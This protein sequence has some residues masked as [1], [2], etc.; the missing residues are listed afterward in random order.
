MSIDR[1]QDR[2]SLGSFTFVDARRCRMPRRHRHPYLCTFHARR[3]AMIF[4]GEK[5]GE[6]IARFLSGEYVPAGDLCSALGR[7]FAAVAQV[8]VE[9]ETVAVLAHLG[10]SLVQSRHFA[11][12]ECAIAS[13]LASGES[14]ILRDTAQPTITSPAKPPRIRAISTCGRSTVSRSTLRQAPKSPLRQTFQNQELQR[15][16]KMRDFKSLRI[17]V[18]RK[19][20][21]G[22][23]CTRSN[24]PQYISSQ[25]GQPLLPRRSARI[26]VWQ[27][28]GSLHSPETRCSTPS[29]PRA[30][31]LAQERGAP[32]VACAT[33]R[34]GWPCPQ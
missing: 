29:C 5:A 31:F 21:R 14:V 4:A 15:C 16:S 26:T 19:R 18:Y 25:D 11:Q 28:A 12:D 24:N 6:E 2:A 17:S 23:P 8:Q 34:P 9:P 7:L 30:P 13:G 22:W 20:G 3:E 32:K 33:S 27:A 1:S 10:Q